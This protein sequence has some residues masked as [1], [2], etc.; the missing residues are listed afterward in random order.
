MQAKDTAAKLGGE[1]KALVEKITSAAIKEAKA[2]TSAVNAVKA[3]VKK[4]TDSVGKAGIVAPA[5]KV[6]C[7]GKDDIGRIGMN[8][9]KGRLRCRQLHV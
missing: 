5:D 8:V 7:K 2:A 6:A 3:D 1:N 4:L 9:K